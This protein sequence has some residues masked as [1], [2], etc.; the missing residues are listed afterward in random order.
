M[1]EVVIESRSPS[2][3]HLDLLL[4]MALRKSRAISKAIM[5]NWLPSHAEPLPWAADAVVG[6][7]TW[8]IGGHSACFERLHE[9]VH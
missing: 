3:D 9:R 4:V 5:V 1:T 7:T 2:Q 8:W 6:A